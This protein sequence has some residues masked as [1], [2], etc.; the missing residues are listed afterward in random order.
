MTD[1][2]EL[3]KEIEEIKERN[4]AVEKNKAW[5]GSYTRRILLII[6]TYLAIALYLNVIEVDRPWINAIV[7]AVGFLLSTLS[8][9]FFKGLWSRYIYKK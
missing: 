3:Q 7:P 4:R 1:I 8:L 5:E 2:Q 6:F 9:S